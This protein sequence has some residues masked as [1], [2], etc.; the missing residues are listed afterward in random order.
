MM[1]R[2]LPIVCEL[3]FLA[4]SAQAGPFDQSEFPAYFLPPQYRTV[5]YSQIPPKVIE[6]SK[7][8]VE[9]AMASE[10]RRMTVPIVEP[11]GRQIKVVR[12]FDYLKTKFAGLD[13]NFLPSAGDVRSEIG[14]LYQRVYDGEKAG[15]SYQETLTR[16]ASEAKDRP[17]SEMKGIGSDT[18]LH[19]FGKDSNKVR[20]EVEDIVNSVATKKRIDT[21]KPSIERNIVPFGDVVEE[22]H[23]HWMTEDGGPSYDKFAFDVKTGTFV[24][25]PG[26]PGAAEKIIAGYFDYYPTQNQGEQ[27]L[28]VVRGELELPFLRV[29]AGKEALEKD[30]KTYGQFLENNPNR[31]GPM[32][33]RFGKAVRNT[34]FGETNRFYR[35]REGTL[36]ASIA[37]NVLGNA[38]LIEANKG[39][40]IIPSFLGPPTGLLD[41]NLVKDLP[42]MS[43]KDFIKKYTANGVL[44]HGTANIDA[45]MS[46]MRGNFIQSN[47]EAGQSVYGSSLG[48]GHY[49]TNDFSVAA[50]YSRPGYNETPVVVAE[51]INPQS[52]QR[53]LGLSSLSQ[54]QTEKLKKLAEAAGYKPEDFS[55]YLAEKHN[56]VLIG[57][58]NKEIVVPYKTDFLLPS[59]SPSSQLTTLISRVD[60]GAENAEVAL[61][62]Y[63]NIKKTLVE[64]GQPLPPNLAEVEKGMVSKIENMF[65]S[66]LRQNPTSTG[67]LLAAFRGSLTPNIEKEIKDT[68]IR[69]FKASQQTNLDAYDRAANVQAFYDWNRIQR[70]SG[71]KPT[72][73]QKEVETLLT[74][75]LEQM[76]N[77]LRDPNKRHTV[78][79]VNAYFAYK[80]RLSKT[81]FSIPKAIDVQGSDILTANVETFRKS[82]ESVKRYLHASSRTALGSLTRDTS[83]LFSV[84]ERLALLDKKIIPPAIVS[85]TNDFINNLVKDLK[86]PSMDPLTRIKTA[87]YLGSLLNQLDRSNL[88]AQIGLKRRLKDL[89]NLIHS[90]V[91]M[92][93]SQLKNMPKDPETLKFLFKMNKSSSDWSHGRSLNMDFVKNSDWLLEAA[94]SQQMPLKDYQSLYLGV[95]SNL[96]SAPLETRKYF[97]SDFPK[98]WNNGIIYS[99]ND[100]DVG[101]KKIMGSLPADFALSQAD[102]GNINTTASVIL[103]SDSSPTTIEKVLSVA[104]VKKY[105]ILEKVIPQVQNLSP[106]T[107]ENLLF[108]LLK[109]SYNGFGDEDN[110]S[111][112]MKA[113]EPRRNELAKTFETVVDRLSKEATDLNTVFLADLTN[114]FQTSMSPKTKT[115]LI[116]LLDKPFVEERDRIR[117]LINLKNI[118]SP[119]EMGLL[120]KVLAQNSKLDGWRFSLLQKLPGKVPDQALPDAVGVYLNSPFP[121]LEDK[122]S[123]FGLFS[124]KK[125]VFPNLD[126]EKAFASSQLETSNVPATPDSVKKYASEAKQKIEALLQSSDTTVLGGTSPVA[127]AAAAPAKETLPQNAET[128]AK[129]SAQVLSRGTC[130][131]KVLSEALVGL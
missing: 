29:D 82:L 124:D 71:V 42:F 66:R 12:F 76:G 44:Y 20:G 78:K 53:I 103:A 41:E 22:D 111:A 48:H 72:H 30:V 118:S 32:A 39:A 74:R 79:E 57:T 58:S 9:A 84:F 112:L 68:E 34:R 36:D 50:S 28:R 99:V 90:N 80:E 101:M 130:V 46:I 40:P 3:I 27:V 59:N 23:F 97:Y 104:A 52:T 33:L 67:D 128:A 8:L 43:I 17:I 14:S 131:D 87:N 31:V 2:R 77:S 116:G 121:S 108:D 93:L 61:N 105:D 54:K 73:T 45:A 7:K 89:D 129:A 117:Y 25:P 21:E 19:I 91:Q 63:A 125:I 37:Q 115:T 62:N 120:K 85:M 65:I 88:G 10:Y 56:I 86:T 13:V 110:F 75:G 107:I 24:D 4:L 49:A 94:K 98:T 123:I 109:D 26:H 69:L 95:Y 96:D 47:E 106:K 6:E 119:E 92:G 64:L 122:K 16:I 114:K 5:P 60:P 51:T 18:D 1:W 113:L 70:T 15:V 83:E 126:V 102:A 81:D 55:N 11:N 127:K 38:S 100:R 35:A